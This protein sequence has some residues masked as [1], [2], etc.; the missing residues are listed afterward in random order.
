[1]FKATAPLVVYKQFYAPLCLQH[2][3]EFEFLVFF[4]FGHLKRE[5]RRAANSCSEDQPGF[6]ETVFPKQRC[7]LL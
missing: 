3:R 2:H 4:V 6:P 5:T 1:M 7:M